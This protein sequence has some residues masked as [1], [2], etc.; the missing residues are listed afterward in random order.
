VEG[1]PWQFEARVLLTSRG[2][3][4]VS[5]KREWE[6]HVYDPDNDSLYYQGHGFLVGGPLRPMQKADQFEVVLR[7]GAPSDLKPNACRFEVIGQDIYGN[8][9]RGS[10]P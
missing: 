7:F 1:G 5:F 9:L 3:S 6:L 2:D 8:V 4:A 10:W